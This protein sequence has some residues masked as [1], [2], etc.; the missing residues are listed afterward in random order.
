[1]RPSLWM[2]VVTLGC[3]GENI[4]GST[5]EPLPEPV[6]C[7][8]GL[9]VNQVTLDGTQG[10]TSLQSALDAAEPESE[11]L[12][13]PGFYMGNFVASAPVRIRALEGR[14]Q[15][16]LAG[17]EGA[18]LSIPGGSEIEGLTIQSGAP[19][20]V[21]SSPGAVRIVNSLITDNRAEH[22]AG[23]LITEK[24]EV[25]LV[26]TQ[27]S[28]NIALG[29]GGGVWV[30][31]GAVLE[32][33]ENSLVEANWAG[34]FGGGVWLESA[35]LRGG[36]VKDNL[37]VTTHKT[38]YEFL[39][40]VQDA[41]GFGG[42]GVALTGTGSIVDTE[43][44]RNQGEG[45]ALSVTGG[46]A[47]LENVWVYDNDGRPGM[48]GGLGVASGTVIGNGTSRFERNLALDG[49]GGIIVN[50]AIHGVTFAGNT[51]GTIGAPGSGG[52]LLIENGFLEDVVL[53]DNRAL[54]GG[55]AM[56]RGDVRMERVVVQK[57]QSEWEGGGLL[58]II[59]G[60]HPI[61][62]VDSEIVGNEA[63]Q[64][65][66]IY[67]GAGMKITRTDIIDNV[68]TSK[69]GG[70]YINADTRL[71]DSRVLANQASSGGGAHVERMFAAFV[72]RN[73]DFGEGEQDNTPD[74]VSTLLGH[75]FHGA[76][77][78]ADFTCDHLDCTV[79]P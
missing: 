43:I 23:L 36:V 75:S 33:S 51:A 38:Y 3:R 8:N 64:G 24:A 26:G 67:S 9:D 27:I 73:T 57:N 20:V 21:V 77:A 37:V 62:I 13:C 45:G 19:G 74:D 76:G 2:L 54:S 78:S 30:R 7:F 15:T 58:V 65:A 71:I 72:V 63:S 40:H 35:H 48:G 10:F 69:G 6:G 42:S 41:E 53:E 49:G 28:N 1:M 25:L 60:E 50:G 11:L 52:G 39:N 59:K 44:A 4:D 55:G 79:M 46:S 18:T 5:R 68:A 61:E 56:T 31:P 29:R 66:G 34:E 32:L 17:A 22:G 14:D 12:L 16:V 70:L 47:T